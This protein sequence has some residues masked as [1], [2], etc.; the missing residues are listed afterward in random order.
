MI[1]VGVFFKVLTV[2]SSEVQKLLGF[3][4][5]AGGGSGVSKKKVSVFRC[6]GLS[7]SDF[8]FWIAD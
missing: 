5:S 8:G 6:Q 3:R 2:Q 7:I 1:F 4:C